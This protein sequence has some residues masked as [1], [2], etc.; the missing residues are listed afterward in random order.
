[1]KNIY[2]L[3]EVIKK[4]LSVTDTYRQEN[5]ILLT[6]GVDNFPVTS[7]TMTSISQ[8]YSIVS[9]SNGN[10]SRENIAWP[11]TWSPDRA[12]CPS[13]KCS[14]SGSLCKTQNNHILFFK[15]QNNHIL[16]FM[17]KNNYIQ[18]AWQTSWTWTWTACHKELKLCIV[19]IPF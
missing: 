18:R 4:T 11:R 6:C 10:P 7:P 2:D 5:N 13:F 3:W 17:T 8:A 14:C 16:F 1:M 19:C 12:R 9:L 15:T